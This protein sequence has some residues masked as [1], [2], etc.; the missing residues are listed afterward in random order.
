M[1]YLDLFPDDAMKI[2][3]RNVHDLHIIK[4]RRER[5]EKK[6]KEYREKKANSR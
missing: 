3:N 5:K 1:N 2:I 6:R 4:R